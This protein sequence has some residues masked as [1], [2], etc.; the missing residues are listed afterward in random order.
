M[1]TATVTRTFLGFTILILSALSIGCAGKA[2]YV[3]GRFTD[4]ECDQI[5]QGA[6]IWSDAGFPID[7][8]FGAHVTGLA[9]D[10]NEI[11]RTDSRGMS[12]LA[13]TIA[14]A[15][16]AEGETTPDLH[17]I[18]INVETLHEPLYQV[19]AHE[20]GHSLGLAHV[21]DRRAIM[22]TDAPMLGCLTRADIDQLCS[23]RDCPAQLKGCDE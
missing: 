20:F 1:S 18:A 15:R 21:A 8:V 9:V 4:E 2:W 3:D 11:F 10:R 12:Y 5:S 19:T 16:E 6:K 23:V 14:E 13:P 17:R 22:G 7:L